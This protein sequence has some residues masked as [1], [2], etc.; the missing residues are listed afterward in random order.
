MANSLQGTTLCK[1]EATFF[2][3]SAGGPYIHSYIGHL[4]TNGNGHYI[5]PLHVPPH[6]GPL[7]ITTTFLFPQGNLIPSISLSAWPQEREKRETDPGNEVVPK[8][9]VQ[10]A[11][12]RDAAVLF[13]YLQVAISNSCYCELFL[14]S[15][16]GLSTQDS[17]VTH[18]LQTSCRLV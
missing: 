9:A 15:S 12:W 5:T 14:I 16:E 13:S 3:V 17:T 18:F 8:V 2:F 7:S 1:I 6:N 4:S 10:Q 11:L